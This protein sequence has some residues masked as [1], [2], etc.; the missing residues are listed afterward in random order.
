MAALD[1]LIGQAVWTTWRTETRGK[2][3]SKVPYTVD[4]ARAKANDP[5]TWSTRGE[6]EAAVLG[7]GEGGVN[8]MLGI[9]VDGPG[10]LLGG[11]DLDR[12]LGEEGDIAP[13]AEE[14]VKLIDSYTEVSPS[15]TGIRIFFAYVAGE[16]DRHWRKHVQRKSPDGGK[17][18]GIEVYFAGHF[19]S[20]TDQVWQ[21][22]EALR[23]VT[24]VA[25]ASLQTAMRY[26]D[27]KEE[28]PTIAISD[29]DRLHDA[30]RHMHNHDLSW[31][32]WNTIG[33]AIYN[34]THGTSRGFESFGYW[35]AKSNKYNERDGRERWDNYR[36]S[37]GTQ[38][39]EGTIFHHAL[40]SGWVD[41]RPK[42]QRNGHDHEPP[43]PRGDDDSGET[44]APREERVKVP[45]LG[46]LIPA[47]HD[48]L[49]LPKRRWVM[50]R[51]L[52]RGAVTGIVG[53]GSVG[54]S[55]LFNAMMIGVATNRNLVG[56]AISEPGLT[57]HYNAED[58][59]TENLLRIFALLRHHQILDDEITA[60]FS[61]SSGLEQRLLVAAKLRDGTITSGPHYTML[62]EFLMDN[63]MSSFT[64]EPFVSLC[65]GLNE[66]DNVEV[67]AVVSIIR[68]LAH[69]TQTALVVGHHVSRPPRGRDYANDPSD[70]HVSRGATAFINGCRIVQQL[71]NMSKE[72]ASEFGISESDRNRYLRRDLGKANYSLKPTD[73]IAW[74]YRHSVTLANGEEV[75][76]LAV[77]QKN[78]RPLVRASEEEQTTVGRMEMDNSKKRLCAVIEQ[79]WAE[80]NPYSHA[81]KS[82][83][84]LPRAMAK[85]EP[86]M[87]P[88]RAERLMHEMLLVGEIIYESSAHVRG[89]RL[90]HQGKKKEDAQ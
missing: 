18:E 6:V 66:N 31:E 11:I 38:V 80:R 88:R 47:E 22:Y 57:G 30:I 86:P 2:T 46:W 90:P 29:E 83:R 71:T 67:D 89:L 51:T 69:R 24:K 79:A 12:C 74:Y 72:D 87:D 73:A 42:Q 7:H 59:D 27:G 78:G 13:W 54:K 9:P 33:M 19:M 41:P 76:V 50:G 21:G 34:A 85:A 10:V 23:Q 68:R 61:P 64:M 32:E 70:P 35:S 82:G 84:F 58:P 55:T 20:V 37:P 17:D 77:A 4:G 65:E 49:Q 5:S 16:I 1:F 8:V 44:D 28:R 25:L 56:E 39:G 43:P 36:K 53:L 3:P 45:M 60:R 14:V 48:E 75:G 62:S 15:G 26:F 63:H 52:L 81:P 40:N